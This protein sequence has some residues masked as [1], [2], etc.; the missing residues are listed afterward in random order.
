LRDGVKFDGKTDFSGYERLADKGRR[1]GADF[2]RA[3]VES[4]RA[5]QEGQVVLDHTPFYAESGGQIGDA[6]LLVGAARAS[7][8]ATRKR[9]ARSHA[10]IGVLESG[11]LRVGD[12]LEAQV[13]AS[14]AAIALNHSATHLLH[15]A[16]REVLGKHVQQK[17]RWSRPIDCVSISR[18]RRR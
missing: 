3:R 12:R 7:S 15:A 6:G 16:L 8:C 1:H 18:I 13:D 11:E 5:G 2:R 17:A 14:G 10:H 4:L 9:S